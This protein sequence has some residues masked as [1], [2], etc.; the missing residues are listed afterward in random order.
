M[1]ISS[2]PSVQAATA[3]NQGDTPDAVNILV[4][5]K[6]LDTQASA[7]QTLLQALPQP[8]LASQG[9]LGTTLNTYA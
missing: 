5:K 7:A 4:L 8:T 2:T 3:A 1:N 9:P 6:A